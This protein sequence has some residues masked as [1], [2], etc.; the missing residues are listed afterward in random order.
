ML[1]AIITFLYLLWNTLALKCDREERQAYVGND[2]GVTHIVD[3]RWADPRGAQY[4]QY[5]H[6]QPACVSVSYGTPGGPR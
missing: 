4:R 3:D 1:R 6:V 2:K 5:K